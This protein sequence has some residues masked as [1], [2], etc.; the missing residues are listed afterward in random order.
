MALLR[1]YRSSPDLE[2]GVVARG[3]K[4]QVRQKEP[5]LRSV[6][7]INRGAIASNPKAMRNETRT[8]QKHLMALFDHTSFERH[9]Q[10]ESTVLL[11]GDPANAIYR[12]SSGTVRCCT[13]DADGG[14][15][16]FSFAKKGDYIGISDIDTWHFT[17]EAVDHVVLKSVPRA[18]LEQALAVNICLREEVRTILCDLLAQRERQI[19]SLITKKAPERLLGFLQDFSASRS[20]TG[21]VVLPMNRRDIGDH[22]GM[23]T[24][25]ASRSFGVLKNRGDIELETPEKYRLVG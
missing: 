17:A 18:V 22:L 23:T 24:E 2:K 7:P 9:F 12:I 6:R 11:H 15:Q 21:F 8:T 25:T 3:R 10:P 20:I 16:I 19:L 5:D 14:R 13:I 1:E 4:P